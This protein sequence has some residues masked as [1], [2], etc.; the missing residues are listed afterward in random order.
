LKLV[1]YLGV[2]SCYFVDRSSSPEANK[3]ST[4]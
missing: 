4:K 2:R 1:D 3:R